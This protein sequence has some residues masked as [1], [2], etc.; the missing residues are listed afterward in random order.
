MSD[1]RKPIFD[2]IRAAR[3]KGF[4]APEVTLLDNALDA[5][6]IPH[7]S[8]APPF[9]S[10]A[11]PDW[12]V[13]ARKLIGTREIVGPQNNG[14]I[15]SQWAKLG[16]SWFNDDETPWCGLFVASCLQA[17][18]LAFP[19]KGAFARA[20]AWKDWGKA[21]SPQ[22][23]A[24]AVFQR[25]GGGHVGFLVGESATEV[26]VLGGNQ[27]N[28]V[29]IMPLAKSRM[30]ACRWPLERSMSAAVPLPAMSGGVVSVN[31]A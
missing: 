29:S 27:G 30:V 17:V 4:T 24:V 18:G 21:C 20:L 9:P 10:T 23:G 15:V 3:G 11:E 31:E 1:P 13:G 5:L 25:E 7:A 6:G 14:W 26:Y 28:M 2:A 8:D 22:L 12:L 16:A 19:G